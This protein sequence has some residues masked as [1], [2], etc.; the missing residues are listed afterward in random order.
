M[1]M[2][3]SNC[4]LVDLLLKSTDLSLSLISLGHNACAST[5]QLEY[6][7]IRRLLIRIMYSHVKYAIVYEILQNKF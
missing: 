1:L 6:L 7:I 5:Y 3:L 4:E 2:H